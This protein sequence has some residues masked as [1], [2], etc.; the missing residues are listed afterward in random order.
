MGANLIG[1]PV[2]GAQR[3]RGWESGTPDVWEMF[4]F[5]GLCFCFFWLIV[6]LGKKTLGVYV[7][8]FL[9]IVFFG[10]KTLGVY[11]FVFFFVNI[12][13]GKKT[14]GVYVVVFFFKAFFFGGKNM[15]MLLSFKTSASLAF[16]SMC[17]L[18]VGG[19]SGTF[20]SFY[21]D[22]SGFSMV[23]PAKHGLHLFG[24]F[25]TLRG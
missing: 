5:L 21:L 18:F 25:M 24:S 4:V 8:V 19:F 3:P 20:P 13:L 17:L 16:V 14:L 10:K 7:F 12:F 2:G 15:F 23:H 11:V 1:I 6:F 9:L 22:F